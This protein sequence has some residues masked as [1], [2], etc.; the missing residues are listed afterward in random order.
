MLMQ[1]T[2]ITDGNGESPPS[3]LFAT[4]EDAQNDN[5]TA[6][7]PNL[8]HVGRVESSYHELPVL[9]T[10]LDGSAEMR[11]LRQGSRA[12]DDR[13]A[14]QFGERR[15]SVQKNAANRSRSA[16]A[17]LDQMTFIDYSMA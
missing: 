2:N 4:V 1:D 5:L 17:A 11:M 10:H 16:I 8:K 13:S 15:L 6:L 9:R 12:V 7:D 3:S 14:N